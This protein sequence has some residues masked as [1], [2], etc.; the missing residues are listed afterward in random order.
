MTKGRTTSHHLLPYLYVE[1]LKVLWKW[2]IKNDMPKGKAKYLSN[3]FLWGKCTLIEL[4]LFCE[5]G[6]GDQK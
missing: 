1:S 2:H 3:F 6:R 5:Q 4:L